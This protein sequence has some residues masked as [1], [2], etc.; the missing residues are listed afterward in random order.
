MLAVGN[1][2]SRLP[3]HCT[4]CLVWSTSILSV[5]KKTPPKQNKTNKTKQNKTKTK[6]K[7]KQKQK[8]TP[9]YQINT[10]SNGQN[11]HQ[12]RLEEVAR[13]LFPLENITQSILKNNISM[14]TIKRTDQCK[15]NSRNK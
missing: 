7:Q 8:Q 9:S 5:Q 13:L 4:Y 14:I 12:G 6:Q 10:N 2:V 11:V 15:E 3:W 1:V